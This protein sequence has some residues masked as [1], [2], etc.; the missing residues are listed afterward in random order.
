MVERLAPRIAV[1]SGAELELPHIL[2]LIDDPTNTVIEPLV[3][4]RD[5]LPRLYESDL[6]LGGGR[7]AGFAVNGVHR[8][9][10]VQALQALANP[11]AFSA[12]Y[13]VTIDTPPMLFAVGDGNHSLATA[14]SLWDRVKA[15]VGMHH[16]SRFALVEVENIHD[17]A[18]HFAPIHRLLFGVGVDVRQ[19]L[20]EAFGSRLS[21]TDVRSAAAMRERVQAT[22]RRPSGRRSDRA[23]PALQ[24]DHDRRPAFH[25][26]G[27]HAAALRRRVDRARRRLRCR[28][29]ARR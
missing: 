17:P 16:P 14:K 12:R 29:R 6:M 27:G 26:G 13:G 4:A 15:S 5:T 25:A 22:V 9:R 23:R 8:E 28:L 7:V 3:A 20:A 18:L 21:C 11:Q 1:R 24:R 19:A 10:A 2:V